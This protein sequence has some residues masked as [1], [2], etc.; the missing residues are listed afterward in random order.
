M[1]A[2]ALVLWQSVRMSLIQSSV[3]VYF[4]SGL[5]TQVGTILK[6]STTQVPL[7]HKRIL[8][9]ATPEVDDVLHISLD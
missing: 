3:T 2:K 6:L 7:I 4:S 9:N 1:F 5:R 8:Q